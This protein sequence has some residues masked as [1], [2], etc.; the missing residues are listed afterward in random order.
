MHL[1][2]TRLS[3]AEDRFRERDDGSGR[4]IQRSVIVHGAFHPI[5][6][7]LLLSDW[8]G[9]T[10]AGWYIEAGVG[11][12]HTVIPDGDRSDI[13]ARFSL[14]TG[15]DTPLSDPDAGFSVWFNLVYR[16]NWTDFDF[17]DGNEVN[18]HHHAGW[19]GFSLRFNGLLF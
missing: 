18:L 5:Y 1:L 7:A 15:V 4:F 13:G 14:G 12:H 6:I 8:L 10:L 2:D 3:F 17:G 16:Y 9:Y 11:V 19:A